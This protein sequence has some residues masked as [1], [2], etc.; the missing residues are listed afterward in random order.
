MTL[1]VVRGRDELTGTA[2]LVLSASSLGAATVLAKVVLTRGVPVLVALACRF[3]LAALILALVAPVLG[4]PLA[5]ARGE[6]R[7]LAALGCLGYGLETIVFYAALRRGTVPAVTLLVFTYPV[8]VVGLASVLSRKSPAALVWAA[9]ALGMIGS[10]IVIFTS[11]RLAITASGAALAL[12]ASFLSATF[13]IGRDRWIRSTHSVTATLYLSASATAFLAI[14][15]AATGSYGR[16]TPTPVLWLVGMGVL[17]SIGFVAWVA[18]I[19]RL[20][21]ARASVLSMMEVVVAASLAVAFLGEPL[22][23]GLVPG[24]LLILTGGVIALSAR[25]SPEHD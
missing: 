20:G 15:A 9:L 4:V 14:A 6:G 10:A 7:Y 1:K 5:P 11:G 18:A 2:L 13:L 22:R 17:T 12:T 21:P 23:A 19:P 16:S 25:G 8:W 24:G 3:G